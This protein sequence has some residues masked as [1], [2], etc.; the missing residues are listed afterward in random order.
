MESTI[1]IQKKGKTKKKTINVCFQL[2]NSFVTK[3][4]T[5][6]KMNASWIDYLNRIIKL[7]TRYKT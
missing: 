7:V 4:E 6:K 2:I 3:E 5:C 1:V